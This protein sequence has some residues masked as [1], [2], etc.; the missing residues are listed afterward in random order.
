MRTTRLLLVLLFTATVAT[1]APVITSVTPSTGPVGGGW[2][3]VIQGTGFSNGAVV[4]FGS[5]EAASVG[6]L[7]ATALQVVAPPHV[8][9]TVS[10]T[11]TQNGDE[12]F[13]L[14]NAFTYADDLYDAFDPILFPIF[15][16]PVHGQGGSEFRTTATVWNKT[17]APAPLYGM[18][19]GCA[20]DP[21]VN[22]RLAFL[23]SSGGPE[24]NLLPECS[25]TAGQL[26]FVPK[27]DTSLGTSLRVW[28]VT[29]QNENHG[30]EIPVV[31][32]KDFSEDIITLLSVPNDPK[33]RLTLRIYGLNRGAETVTIFVLGDDG[34]VRDF[35]QV[36]L[37]HNDNPFHPSYVTY[38]QFPNPAT[39]DDEKFVVMVGIAKGP[40]NV[41]PPPTPLWAFITVTNNETQQITTITP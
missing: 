18:G 1:A 34:H 24:T 26:F 8:A 3:V 32:R 7:S 31:R 33:F 38:T 17:V 41:V 5:T 16:P 10:V 12:T 22:P 40:G 30:V 11:V 4:L 6:F 19:L 25:E 20:V 37:P 36:Q 39:T 14:P 21:A 27:G 13:T 2:S 29:R 15:S 9:G 35:E 28:E 23:V